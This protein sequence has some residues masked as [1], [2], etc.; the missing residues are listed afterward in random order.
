M[1]LKSLLNCLI[2]LCHAEKLSAFLSPQG[3]PRSHMP[4]CWPPPSF[5]LLLTPLQPP[6]ALL[7]SSNHTKHIPAPGPFYLLL[8]LGFP[9]GSVGKESICQTGVMGSIPRS[10][11]FPGEGNGNPLQYSCLRNPMDRGV[12]WATVHGVTKTGLGNY[13]TTATTARNTLS[14]DLPQI[15]VFL[16]FFSFPPTGQDLCCDT[17]TFSS[18]SPRGL[19]LSRC[20]VLVALRHVES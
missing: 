16:F 2:V 15:D 12:W 10:G 17:W 19:L 5:S 14:P 4:F 6:W 11:R 7:G 18:Y 9:S 1:H 13:T 8:L 20:T 3:P